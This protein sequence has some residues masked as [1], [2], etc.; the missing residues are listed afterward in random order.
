MQ[1]FDS[2]PKLITVT[3]EATTVLTNIMARASIIPTVYKNPL[4]YYTYDV[5]DGDT[6]EIVAH[7]YYGSTYDYWVLLYTNEMMDPQWSWPLSAKNFDTYIVKKYTTFDPYTTTHHY[8]KI[9]TQSDSVT[10]ITTE[11]VINIDVDTY[12]SLVETTNTY[13]L[14][15]GYVTVEITKRAV[16]YYN[17]EMNLNESKR[18]IRILNKI[19]LSQFQDELKRLML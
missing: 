14:P 8:E 12:N 5:Q 15:T 1:Y 7:K 4:L 11:N 9:I 6:P 16:S 2:L 10:N 17:Y 19:Y 3:P 13:S 18:T